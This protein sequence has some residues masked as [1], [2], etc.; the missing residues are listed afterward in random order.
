[1]S[2]KGNL[3]V[4]LRIGKKWGLLMGWYVLHVGPRTEKKVAAVCQKHDLP[5]YLPVR[6]DKRIYQ[7]R[8]VIVRK[9]LFPGYL[10]VDLTP[11]TRVHVIRTNHVLQL[12]V[13]P[14]EQQLMHEIEQIRLALAADPKLYSDTAV[15][16]GARVRIKAGVF[17]GIEGVIDQRPGATKVRLN[18]ELVGQSVAVDVE[19]DYLEV[20]DA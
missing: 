6:E 5:H 2:G 7:R 16:K 18:V 4:V 17:M 11:E 3:S 8:R 15:C 10:F 9:P 13:P 20:I 1:M 19:R 14:D 12:I